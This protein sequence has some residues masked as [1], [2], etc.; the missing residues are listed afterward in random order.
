MADLRLRINELPEELNPAPI[1]NIAIDGPSTRRTTLQRAADAVRPYSTEAMAREGLNNATTMTPLR[2]SQAIETLG[3]QRFA[4]AQQG[5][6]ADT[7]VQPTL[8]ISAG[9]GLTGGGTLAANREIA[10]NSAS[11]ASLAL[12]N[13]AVQPARQV[14]AGVGLTGGGSLAADRT[15]S[16]DAT[17]LG[18]LAKADSAV[19]PARAIS[20]GTGLTGGG[21]LTADRTLALNAASVASLAK[22]DSAVQPSRVINAGAGLSGGGDLSA[23]R[24]LS[25]SAATQASLAKADSAVQAPGGTAGQI[26]AKASSDPN[27]VDWVNIEGATAVSYGPQTL[28]L[29]Q[30]GQA[31][32]NIGADVLAG[33]RNQIINGGFDIQQRQ[34]PFTSSGYTLDRW[35]LGLSVSGASSSIVRIVHDTGQTDIPGNPT[36]YLRWIRTVAGSSEISL[37]QKVENVRTLQGQKATLTFYIKGSAPTV[38]TP[39]FEQNFGT[40]NSPSPSV[41]TTLPSVNVTTSWQKVT[42]VFDLPSITGKSIGSSNYLNLFFG[43]LHTS[44][45]ASIDISRVSLVKGDATAEVDPF[46]PRHIQQELALCQRYYE[47]SLGNVSWTQPGN[48]GTA[49]QQMS[50]SYKQEKRLPPTISLVIGVGSAVTAGGAASHFIVASNATGMQLNSFS[51]KADAEL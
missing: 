7:A 38:I 30:Q 45:N 29:A 9:A 50:V 21:N 35:Y 43:W 34:G 25:L 51:W 44:P 40:D 31:R 1:D 12:A 11:I 18:S 17:T 41:W 23:D 15:V 36:F 37:Q 16:L 33:F 8:T 32:A 3:G 4:T 14:I 20:A 46:S 19:Q 24:S 42:R 39:K 49:Q 26:L 48:S 28:T 27:D 22:A 10:L 5:N 47:A 6:K 13:S 2:V